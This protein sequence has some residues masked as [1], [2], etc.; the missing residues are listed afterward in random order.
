MVTEVEKLGDVMN[1]GMWR[2]GRVRVDGGVGWVWRGAI[3]TISL[4]VKFRLINEPKNQ[5]Q[6]RPTLV[7]A[8]LGPALKGQRCGLLT[9]SLLEK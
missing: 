3:A 4:A 2:G 1:N 6:Y 8:G 9:R 7:P 5:Y